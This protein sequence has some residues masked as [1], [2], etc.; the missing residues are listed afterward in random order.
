MESE[1][2]VHVLRR[3]REALLPDG[4]MLDLQVIRPD[5]VVE[6]DGA[7]V[8]EIDGR[9]LFV[10]ADAAA[11]AVD[12]MVSAGLLVEEAVDDHDVLKHYPSGA[13]LVEEFAPKKRKLPAEAVPLLTSIARECVV[14]ERCRLRRLRVASP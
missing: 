1:D 6:V 8:C 11:A 10:T 4:L 9:P 5:P 3:F 12:E 14:R 7:V 2:V 13:V